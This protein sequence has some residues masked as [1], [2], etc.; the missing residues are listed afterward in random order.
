MWIRYVILK[1]IFDMIENLFMSFWMMFGCVKM[2]FFGEIKF[3]KFFYVNVS[4]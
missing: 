2:D 3:S 1:L 4:R